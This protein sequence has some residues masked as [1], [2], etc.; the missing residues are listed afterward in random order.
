VTSV[1]VA[2]GDMNG[3]CIGKRY[4]SCLTVID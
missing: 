4:T 3:G 2:K 1:T